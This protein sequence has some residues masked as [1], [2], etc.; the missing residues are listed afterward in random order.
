M[1][2][3]L[4]GLPI[5]L[6]NTCSFSAAVVSNFTWNRYW[7]YPDSRSKPIRTQLLQFIIVNVVGWGINTGILVL[8]KDPAVALVGALGARTGAAERR[9][10]DLH[11]RLQPGQGHRH[12]GGPVLELHR[13][14][15][16]DLLGR[17]VMRIGIDYTAAARQ[18]AGIGRYT[19]ELVAALLALDSPHEYRLFA[20]VGGLGRGTLDVATAAGGRALAGVRLRPVPLSDDWLARLWHRLR[21]PLPVELVT[22]PLDLFYS[23]DFVLPP[24]RRSTRTLLTVHDLSFLRYPEHFVPRLV[25]YLNRAVP[26][27]VARADLVLAEFRRPPART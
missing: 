22:G 18:R 2:H 14:P 21:L 16:V 19:R 7:T 25:A 9:A 3:R 23:P 12:R 6:A 17:R 4:L 1:L 11:D 20:A 26:A 27:S 15:P 13:Q 10:A 8:L 24:T 5:V